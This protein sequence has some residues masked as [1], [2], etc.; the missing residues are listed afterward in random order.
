MGG[1]GG[2]RPGASAAER[3]THSTRIARVIA[4]EGLWSEGKWAMPSGKPGG[5]F[6]SGCQA[7][8]ICKAPAR[9]PGWRPVQRV[10][11]E[12]GPRRVE[13]SSHPQAWRLE[14]GGRG[15]P[16]ERGGHEIGVLRLFLQLDCRKLRADFCDIEE[17]FRVLLGE[18]GEPEDELEP[19]VAGKGDGGSGGGGPEFLSKTGHEA[20]RTGQIS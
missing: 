18:A 3:Q 17:Y 4:A 9:G 7:A 20:G 15:C 14:A 19:G 16:P 13:G 11:P 2:R 10:C 12:A 6:Q 8:G 1:E 5:Y